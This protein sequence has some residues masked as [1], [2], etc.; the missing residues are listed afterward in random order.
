[1]KTIREQLFE[2]KKEDNKLNKAAKIAGT[3]ALT[4]AGL[5]GGKELTRT[6]I[7]ASEG[8]APA[9][10]AID[11]FSSLHN[12]TIGK[13][14]R[15]VSKG[16][17]KTFTN[18]HPLSIEA[19]DKMGELAAGTWK[20]ANQIGDIGGAVAIPATVTALGLA[21]YNKLKKNKKK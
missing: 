6:V 15:G 11:A 13:I 9:S 20:G 18:E 12:S 3:T 2:G 1:M 5:Y 17:R 7:D 16:I 8:G 19:K 21:A 14:A 4:G 10:D